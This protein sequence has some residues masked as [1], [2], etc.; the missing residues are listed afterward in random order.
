MDIDRDRR[1]EEVC[2]GENADSCSICGVLGKSN[3]ILL[4]A[5]FPTFCF[6]MQQEQTEKD[7]L[8]AT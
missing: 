6:E 8:E 4:W 2:E 5:V 1:I 7:G 3:A